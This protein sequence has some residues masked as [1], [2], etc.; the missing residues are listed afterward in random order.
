MKT[1]T[2]VVL[3]LVAGAAV[4]VGAVCL[5]KKHNDDEVVVEVEETEDYASESDDEEAE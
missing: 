1:W 2:K 4:A 3:G 5:G